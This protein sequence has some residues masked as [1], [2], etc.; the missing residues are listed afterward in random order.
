MYTINPSFWCSFC[1]SSL[2]QTAD[3]KPE[4]TTEIELGTQLSFAKRR[5]ELDFTWYDKKSTNLSLY[6]YAPFIIYLAQ[7]QTLV[8]SGTEVWK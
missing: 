5:V 1:H 7:V 4:F 8:A 2:L 3:L 6:Y